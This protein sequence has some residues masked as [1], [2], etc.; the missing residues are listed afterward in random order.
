MC[1][2]LFAYMVVG[3]DLDQGSA[4]RGGIIGHDKQ[5]A[6]EP[7]RIMGVSRS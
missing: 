6:T 2:C 4:L 7:R 3:I 1:E 5:N